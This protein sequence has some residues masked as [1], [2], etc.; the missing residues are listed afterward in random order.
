M[1]SNPSTSLIFCL[2]LS[3]CALP[4]GEEQAEDLHSFTAVHGNPTPVGVLSTI[5]VDA[6]KTPVGDP[7]PIACGL[8]RVEGSDRILMT[9]SSCLAR[10]VDWSGE[11]ADPFSELKKLLRGE[12]KK[13]I[14]AATFEATSEV[15]P[16]DRLA[17][18]L[19]LTGSRCEKAAWI[20]LISR[21]SPGS[22]DCTG[23][24]AAA[25]SDVA[26][27]RTSHPMPK[28]LP[29]A[30]R[31]PTFELRLDTQIV[32]FA[33]SDQ[34]IISK[35]YQP[36]YELS[37]QPPNAWALHLV[38]YINTPHYKVPGVP[39]LIASDDLSE[40]VLQG[41]VGQETPLGQRLVRV[42]TGTLLGPDHW[43]EVYSNR[44]M[45]GGDD[46]VYAPLHPSGCFE[47]NASCKI[48]HLSFDQVSPAGQLAEDV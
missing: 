41:I 10:L 20:H 46:V 32:G 29:Q 27:L 2:F 19:P 33:L 8:V 23:V 3:A 48:R 21:T 36:G 30:K 5:R 7:Q 11:E 15:Y 17:H 47:R 25:S 16:I 40:W 37:S 28:E 35:F 24:D 38:S 39:F 9:A 4:N 12:S 43:F 18:T 26:L 42:S 6:T 22:S 44:L 34:E 1:T 31:D 13:G 14:L 45:R